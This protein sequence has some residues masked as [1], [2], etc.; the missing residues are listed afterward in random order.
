MYRSLFAV[1]ALFTVAVAFSQSIE[2][3]SCN[4]C[5]AAPLE[6]KSPARLIIRAKCAF[7]DGTL[8][9]QQDVEVDAS[10]SPQEKRAVAERACQPIMAAA[11]AKCDDLANRVDALKGQWRVAE[12]YSSHARQ[13]A[14]AIKQ[15]IAAAPSYCK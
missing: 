14:T 1:I 6:K 9:A 8:V 11:S 4:D 3:A 7:P 5:K 12:L 10:L 13:L 15:A 2:V